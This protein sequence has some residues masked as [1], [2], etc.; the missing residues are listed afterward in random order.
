MVK[1]KK[2]NNGNILLIVLCVIIVFFIFGMCAKNQVSK[3]KSAT[4]PWLDCVG[5]CEYSES[6]GWEYQ[7]DCK[8]LCSALVKA[9]LS[10]NK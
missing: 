7:G 5:I 9:G 6:Q 3:Y 10:V 2:S 1:S 8:F 4:D